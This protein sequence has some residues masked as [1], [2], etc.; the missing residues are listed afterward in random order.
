[1]DSTRSCAPLVRETSVQLQSTNA[2]TAEKTEEH[3]RP[4]SKTIQQ[5]R[6]PREICKTSIPG[7][8]PGGASNISHRENG[9]AEIAAMRAKC[10]QLAP[11]DRRASGRA[12]QIGH[13]RRIT[14]CRAGAVGLGVR[15]AWW[16]TSWPRALPGPMPRLIQRPPR[17]ADSATDDHRDRRATLL[18]ELVRLQ[19]RRRA[20]PRHRRFRSCGAGGTNTAS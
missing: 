5:D 19:V 16:P 8:N 7:S 11:R 9:W 10:E 14:R 3:Q 15:R 12:V 6:E 18:L 1:V 2:P 20:A 4:E 17:L 13:G